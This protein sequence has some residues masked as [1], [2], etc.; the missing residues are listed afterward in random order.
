MPLT[1]TKVTKTDTKATTQVGFV[2]ECARLQTLTRPFVTPVTRFV[3]F[4]TSF[5]TF[6]N[7]SLL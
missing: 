2:S 3:T 7:V 6:V 5:V 1:T 4:V